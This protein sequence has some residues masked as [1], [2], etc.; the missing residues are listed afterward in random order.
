M[1]R[2]NLPIVLFAA[3]T[4]G[5][6]VYHGLR[7]DRW[8]TSSELQNAIGRLDGVPSSLGDW[9]GE[10]E[11][12]DAED[13]KRAGI[14]GHISY[15]FRNVVTGEKVSMLIVCGRSGPIAVHT[16]EICYGGAGFEAFRERYRKEIAIDRHQ[17]G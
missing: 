10:A 2:T 3:M 17:T 6:G 9:H 16:P 11:P 12:L 13:L 7:T 14:K 8:R 5:A 4:L 1:I 15:R